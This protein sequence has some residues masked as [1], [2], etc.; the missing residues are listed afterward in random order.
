MSKH[1][2]KCGE[3][4]ENVNPRIHV[5]AVT[6][7]KYEL[8]PYK[9]IL[10]QTLTPE[11]QKEQDYRLAMDDLFERK[12]AL[13]LEIANSGFNNDERNLFNSMIMRL[14]IMKRKTVESAKNAIAE[15]LIIRD[16]MRE[17]APINPG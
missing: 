7:C 16:K 15:L 11:A 4:F 10:K 9:D 13:N 5:C 2:I 3:E 6:D 8:F 12:K 1:C 17:K 14:N